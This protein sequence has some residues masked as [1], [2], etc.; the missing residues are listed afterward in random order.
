MKTQDFCYWLQGYVELTGEQPSPEQWAAIKE[1]LA[2]VFNKVTSNPIEFIG[3]KRCS[4]DN[5]NP[6]DPLRY[7]DPE[8]LKGG[9]DITATSIT[10]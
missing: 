7:I 5:G 8:R 6:S 3:K 10:C 2:L 9:I 1:H 4:Y